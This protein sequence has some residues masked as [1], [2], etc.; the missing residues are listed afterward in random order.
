MKIDIS[1]IK[2]MSFSSV[3]NML[4]YKCKLCQSSTIHT[5]S[6]KDMCFWILNF[7]VITVLALHFLSA[8]SCGV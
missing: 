1:K 5:D 3:T 4:I 8:L 6:I 2:V 7:I